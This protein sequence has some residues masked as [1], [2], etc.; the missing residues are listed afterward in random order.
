MSCKRIF[1]SHIICK[2]LHSLIH[3]SCC[4]LLFKPEFHNILLLCDE[5]LIRLHSFINR[6][7]NLFPIYSSNY[8]LPCLSSIISCY[9]LLFLCCFFIY[10]FECMTKVILHCGI[11][12]YFHLFY[13][14][15]HRLCAIERREKC[16]A[17][18]I[19]PQTIFEKSFIKVPDNG[20]CEKSHHCLTF[21]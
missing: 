11:A 8:Y 21:T 1:F 15:T 13:N 17:R 18:K 14:I 7:Y 3:K 20:T 6:L 19:A 5:L 10:K 12:F 9:I 2:L 16:S 4:F